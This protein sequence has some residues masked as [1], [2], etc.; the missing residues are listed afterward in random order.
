MKNWNWQ[1]GGRINNSLVLKLFIFF[2]I[3]HS[4]SSSASL[5][6]SGV[7]RRWGLNKMAPFLSVSDSIQ[8]HFLVQVLFFKIV[9]HVFHPCLCLPRLHVPS[10]W[11]YNALA[12]NL[13]A[14]ILATCLN[15][16]QSCFYNLVY[17]CFSVFQFIPD[18]L[19]MN[20]ISSGPS[21]YSS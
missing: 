20:P 12:G 2:L 15:H 19:I 13:L 10:T 9:S 1:V 3:A 17:Q 14:S 6:R 5:F 21:C 8:G 11:Q 4:S 16:R 7:C 18:F